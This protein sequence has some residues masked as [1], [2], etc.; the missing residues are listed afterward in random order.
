MNIEQFQIGDRV[1]IN[2]HGWAKIVEMNPLPNNQLIPAEIVDAVCT[3]VRLWPEHGLL[4]VKHSWDITVLLA[5]E[6]LERVLS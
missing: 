4:S 1:R 6:S 5:P 3:V 2:H